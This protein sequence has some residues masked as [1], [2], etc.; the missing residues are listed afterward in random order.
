[1][2]PVANPLL[3]WLRKEVIA[4]SIPLAHECPPSKL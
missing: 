4:Y 3:A 1:M 2:E